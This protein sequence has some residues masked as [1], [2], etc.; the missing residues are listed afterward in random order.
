MLLLRSDK[1]LQWLAEEKRRTE[2]GGE[3]L[4]VNRFCRA[5]LNSGDE[6]HLFTA[7]WC[8]RQSEMDRLKKEF[9]G[10]CE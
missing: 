1:R 5:A 8:M 6:L 9:E 7:A 10:K 4:C 2:R 3:A